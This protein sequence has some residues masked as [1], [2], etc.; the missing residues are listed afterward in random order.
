[1]I[2][3]NLLVSEYSSGYVFLFLS[4]FEFLRNKETAE[5][6]MIYSLLYNRPII[7]K[8]PDSF[9]CKLQYNRKCLMIATA[10]LNFPGKIGKQECNNILV[11]VIRDVI[12]LNQ[13]LRV[14]REYYK[15]L[16]LFLL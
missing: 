3:F 2:L 9:I 1:M 4:R 8:T 6:L 13:Y 10:L 12:N 15:Q 5:L 11:D 14:I 7:I 16:M